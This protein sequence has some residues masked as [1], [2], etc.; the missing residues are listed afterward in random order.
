MH[1]SKVFAKRDMREAY[2]Y[3][4]V[5]EESQKNTN[6]YT[7]DRVHHSKWLVY[8]IKNAF[9]IFGRVLAEN[10]GKILVMI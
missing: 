6:F 7:H 4:Q 3:I 8:I 10:I 9:E 2:T 5:E 1:G